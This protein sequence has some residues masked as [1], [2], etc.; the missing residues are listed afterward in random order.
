MKVMSYEEI[1]LHLDMTLEA[2]RMNLVEA[3]VLL[4]DGKEAAP[5][6]A[7]DGDAG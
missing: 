7:C 2:V 1:A 5:S 4:S 3:L 6:T